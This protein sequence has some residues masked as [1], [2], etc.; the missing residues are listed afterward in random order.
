LGFIFALVLEVG[1]IFGVGYYALNT[2]INNVFTMFGMTNEDANGKQYINTDT[3]TGGVTTALELVSKLQEM[4]SGIG[5]VTLKDM[6]ELFPAMDSLTET[7]YT[8]LGAYVEINET[9]LEQQQ[10]MDLPT[11]IQNLVMAIQPA[12]IMENLGMGDALDGNAIVKA[13]IA[14]NEA[15]YVTSEQVSYPLYYDEYTYDEDLGKYYRTL[16][17]SGEDSFPYELESVASQLLVKTTKKTSGGKTIYRLYFY[18]VEDGVSVQSDEASESEAATATNYK[19]YAVKSENGSYIYSRDYEY[20]AEYGK[21]AVTGRKNSDGEWEVK[22]ALTGNYYY[23]ADGNKVIVK[24]ITLATLASN[25]TEPLND[26]LV[27]DLFDGQEIISEIFGETSLG[28]LISGNVDFE[29]LINDLKLSTVIDIAPTN[30]VLAYLG[31]KVSNVTAV[32]G[33]SYAYTATYNL[34]DG[35]TVECFIETETKNGGEVISNVYYY[36]GTNKVN[37]E[38]CTVNGI[39]D[40]VDGIAITSIMEVKAD[41]AIMAYLGFGISSITEAAGDGYTHTATLR[42]DDSHVQ[43]YVVTNQSGV[44]TSVYYYENNEKVM[45][46]G[47]TIDGLNDKVSSLTEELTIGD[48]ITI[49]PDDSFMSKLG[50]YKIAEVGS[51]VD[52]FTIDDFMTVDASDA[53]MMYISYGITGLDEGKVSGDYTIFTG[54]DSN[55]NVVYIKTTKNGDAY[56]IVGFYSDETLTSQTEIDATNINGVGDRV[57]GL[58]DN[59]TLGEIVKGIDDTN[60]VLY[61]IK[62]STINQI[63]TA[64]QNL[65][66]QEIYSDNIY[67]DGDTARKIYKVDSLAEFNANYLYYI[68]VGEDKFEFVKIGDLERGK[69]TLEVFENTYQEAEYYTYGAP[70][71]T[72]KF[73][74]YR[75]DVGEHGEVGEKIYSVNDLGDLMGNVTTNINGATIQDLQDAGIITESIDQEVPIYK[76]EDGYTYYLQVANKCTI[77]QLI[78]SISLM[79]EQGY[80]NARMNIDPYRTQSLSNTSSQNEESDEDASSEDAGSENKDE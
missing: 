40:A 80:I 76:S 34:G 7:I 70:S 33:E 62:D 63:P 27:S 79:L 30:T 36:D 61:A 41:D 10:F 14:G 67:K 55:G 75:E 37:V 32:T 3:S 51:A 77:D 8:S 38:C 60:K 9:E 78:K 46:G 66:I 4:V 39:A 20:Y 42:V 6:E 18:Q 15:S 11:Y 68:K 57:S 59:L 65:A 69:L 53:I 31:Y 28:D 19:Y 74:L 48:V 50:G 44:I 16:P 24:P 17:V 26:M 58:C 1:A 2:D 56:E 49:D 22:P 64:I 45:V 13:I 52:E 12:G 21:D 54:T 72:W 5:A 23:D 47:T 43:A 25:A 73:M 71:S 29:A 35:A